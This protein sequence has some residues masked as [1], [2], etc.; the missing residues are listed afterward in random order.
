MAFFNFYRT[1]PVPAN[2]TFVPRYRS[3]CRGEENDPDV[4]IPT[5]CTNV[6]RSMSP[7]TSIIV[8]MGKDELKIQTQY[9]YT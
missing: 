2:D 6:S 5:L 4:L 7:I 3:H 1:A 9:P 8:K